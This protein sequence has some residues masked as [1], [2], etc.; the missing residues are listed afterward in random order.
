[1]LGSSIKKDLDYLINHVFLPPKLPQK[2]DEE[3]HKR[4][5]SLLLHIVDVAEQYKPYA[6]DRKAWDRCIRM[7][8]SAKR[9]HQQLLATRLIEQIKEMQFDGERNIA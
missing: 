6:L 1:M 2:A 7:L 4:E 5:S 3:L 8:V 9:V